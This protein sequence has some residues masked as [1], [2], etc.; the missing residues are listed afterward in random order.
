LTV[1][2][3]VFVTF[4]KEGVA[5]IDALFWEAGNEEDEV[6]PSRKSLLT[7]DIR[8]DRNKFAH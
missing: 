7:N 2:S 8:G 4:N 6:C 1:L 5:S 3:Q